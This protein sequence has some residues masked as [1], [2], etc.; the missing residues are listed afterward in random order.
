[1]LLQFQNVMVLARV[2]NHT[3]SDFPPHFVFGA[4][5]SS[6]QVEGPAL[7]DGR[8][9]SIWDTFVHANKCL[10]NGANGNIA[11]DQY[12]KYKVNISFLPFCFLAY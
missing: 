7:E 5:T 6:Y 12:H 11:C 3:R 8:T 10:S 2:E 4:G 9:P 1:M